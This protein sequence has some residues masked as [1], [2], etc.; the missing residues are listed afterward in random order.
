MAE[1]RPR[2]TRLNAK[3]A[4]TKEAPPPKAPTLSDI[5]NELSRLAALVEDLEARLYVLETRHE[6]Y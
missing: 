1:P 2:L 4:E 3:T 5:R 6:V